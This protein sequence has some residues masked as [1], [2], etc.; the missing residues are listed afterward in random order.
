MKH[1]DGM[2]NDTYNTLY[3]TK[4][5]SRK[6]PSAKKRTNKKNEVSDK[7]EFYAKDIQ[8]EELHEQKEQDSS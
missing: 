6:E 1:E 8:E 4:N 5:V 7:Q 3:K 2:K